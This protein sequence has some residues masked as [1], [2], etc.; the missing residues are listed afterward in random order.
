[1]SARSG[2]VGKNHPGLIWGHFNHFF[3]WAGKKCMFSLGGPMAGVP[4]LT[5]A[6]TDT[7]STHVVASSEPKSQEKAAPLHTVSPQQLP[8]D[9]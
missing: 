9:S 4:E 1:M 8:L 5:L 7:T 6:T 3:L 2:L